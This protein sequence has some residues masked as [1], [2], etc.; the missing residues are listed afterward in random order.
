MRGRRA[1]FGLGKSAALSP[2]ARGVGKTC[3][4][5]AES[6]DADKMRQAIYSL[7]QILLNSPIF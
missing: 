1:K 3:R 6:S 2:D 5:R 4:I 7:Q